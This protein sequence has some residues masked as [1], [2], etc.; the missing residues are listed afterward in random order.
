MLGTEAENCKNP[1]LG[2]WSETKLCIT[3]QDIH[4][5]TIGSGSSCPVKISASCQKA[6][7]EERRI[8]EQEVVSKS[9]H[10]PVHTKPLRY[11]PKGRYP[12]SQDWRGNIRV[13]TLATANM[14]L[15]R[16]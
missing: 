14:S 8:A 7:D 15:K 1:T 5:N 6:V 13:S 10:E 11:L 3:P 9:Q 12:T 16:V 4:P 2:T